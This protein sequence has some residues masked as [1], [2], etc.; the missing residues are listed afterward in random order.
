MMQI[1]PTLWF[2]C[3]CMLCEKG[4]LVDQRPISR[5]TRFRQREVGA[6]RHHEAP[7][8]TSSLLRFRSLLSLLGRHQK[9]MLKASSA[10]SS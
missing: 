1:L 9:K 6:Q 8:S 5:V 3:L 10:S 7:A 4:R 2:K